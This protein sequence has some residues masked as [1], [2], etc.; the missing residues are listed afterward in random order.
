[1]AD[2]PLIFAHVSQ[3]CPAAHGTAHAYVNANA[4]ANANGQPIPRASIHL[5]ANFQQRDRHRCNIGAGP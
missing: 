3:P 5:Q 1:M 2:S 4:N